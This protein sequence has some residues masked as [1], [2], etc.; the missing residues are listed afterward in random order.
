M[1]VGIQAAKGESNLAVLRHNIG[2]TVRV[3]GKESECG[4]I[5]LHDAAVDIGSNRKLALTFAR[6]KFV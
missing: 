2:S 6:R 4:L 3:W 5:T 1:L